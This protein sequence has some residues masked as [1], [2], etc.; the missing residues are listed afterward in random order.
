MGVDPWD[1][2]VIL[3]R[4]HYLK[5]HL[6]LTLW[7]GCRVKAHSRGEGGAGGWEGWKKCTRSHSCHQ[8][9]FASCMAMCVAESMHYA[10]SSVFHFMNLC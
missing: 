9:L 6:I 3:L 2:E 7:L 1:P 4:P 10:A 8:S 5:P